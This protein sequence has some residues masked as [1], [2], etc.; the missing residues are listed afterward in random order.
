MDSHKEDVVSNLV[1]MGFEQKEIE[2]AWHASDI[3][4]IEG[5][6]NWMELHPGMEIEHPT[7]KSGLD[8]EKAPEKT[9]TQNISHLVKPEI[10]QALVQI[11]NSQI[12]SE[13][14]ALFSGNKD[15]DAALNWINEH[16][17]DPDFNDPVQVE[18]KPQLTPEEARAKAKELQKQIRE[19]TMQQEKESE[20]AAEKSRIAMGKELAE[21]K[22]ILDENKK[23]IDLEAYLR[24]KNKTEKEKEDMLR[25]LE[26]D[27]KNKLGDKYKSKEQQQQEKKTTKQAYEAI[28]DKMYKVYRMGQLAVLRTCLNTINTIVGNVIKNPH[29]EKFQKI[30]ASNPNFSAKVKDVIGGTNLL[31]FIGFNEVD[32]FFVLNE[33]DQ[34]FLTEVKEQI[35]NSL[36]R[37]AD[38]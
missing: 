17:N 1:A 12:V 10:V 15:F 21:A 20:L 23:K 9:F 28:Y 38:L 5:L 19:K 14:A 11:G 8:E 16:Q 30:N 32:G 24:E 4:T 13:K 18:Q 37:L 35:E 31:N 36:G 34:H 6:I 26:E 27:K 29:E 7:Q 2:R 3:K 25:I 33:V 22:R